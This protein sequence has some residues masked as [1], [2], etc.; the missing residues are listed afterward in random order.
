MKGIYKGK[1]KNQAVLR[2]GHNNINAGK[3]LYRALLEKK[4]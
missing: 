1:K 2:L 3:S 4:V